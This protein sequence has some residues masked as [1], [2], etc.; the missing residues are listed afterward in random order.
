MLVAATVL[1]LDQ[2]GVEGFWFG[3]AL[4]LV[5][6]AA[7]AVFVFFIDR[8]RILRGAAGSGRAPAGSPGPAV[9]TRV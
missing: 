8:D 2:L 9:S 7:T 1:V 3:G 4:T 5:S 6:G